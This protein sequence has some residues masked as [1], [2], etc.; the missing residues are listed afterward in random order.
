MYV[1]VGKTKRFEVDGSVWIPQYCL[2]VVIDS[3]RFRPL[4]DSA[5][6]RSIMRGYGA[7]RNTSVGVVMCVLRRGVCDPSW[8]K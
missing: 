6:F 5:T 4:S 1:R 2:R 7:N 3:E 8:S